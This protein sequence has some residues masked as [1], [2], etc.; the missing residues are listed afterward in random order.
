MAI[1]MGCG[2]GHQHLL[3]GLRS[4]G[5]QYLQHLGRESLGPVQPSLLYE[6]GLEISRDCSLGIPNKL[7]PRWTCEAPPCGQ[8]GLSPVL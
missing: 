4:L 1:R 2:E 5:P 8:Q 3:P 6:A 7:V